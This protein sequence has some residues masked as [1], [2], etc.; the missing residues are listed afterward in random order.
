MYYVCYLCKYSLLKIC[1]YMYIFIGTDIDIGIE[2]FLLAFL[3][4]G[5][6][7]GFGFELV[8]VEL[9]FV[10]SSS[11]FWTF[12]SLGSSQNLVIQ[13]RAAGRALDA[14]SIPW[15]P[16]VSDD[17]EAPKAPLPI[18]DRGSAWG[19]SSVLVTSILFWNRIGIGW[20]LTSDPPEMFHGRGLVN[21]M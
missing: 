5:S 16:Y 17:G 11:H 3:K 14:I 9:Q 1:R 21:R 15:K 2:N 12:W 10:F 18:R 20:L 19:T 13:N 7:F 4:G 8:I 6:S